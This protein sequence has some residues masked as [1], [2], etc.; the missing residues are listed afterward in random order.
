MRLFLGATGVRDGELLPKPQ[1]IYAAVIE[2]EELQL[3]IGAGIGPYWHA[4]VAQPIM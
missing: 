3:T 1:L 2:L 4:L